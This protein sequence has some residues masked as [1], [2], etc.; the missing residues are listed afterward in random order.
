MDSS[1]VGTEIRNHPG[2]QLV[3]DL[4]GA[5]TRGPHLKETLHQS[6]EEVADSLI[7]AFAL[8]NHS[9]GELDDHYQRHRKEVI[10]KTGLSPMARGVEAEVCM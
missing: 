5:S 6:D 8:M 10:E 2:I 1:S 9:D 7:N 3:V 4:N